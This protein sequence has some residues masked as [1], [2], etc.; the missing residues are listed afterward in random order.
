M[1]DKKLRENFITVIKSLLKEDDFLTKIARYSYNFYLNENYD[2]KKLSSLV[3]T[4]KSMT[5][6]D[7]FYLSRKDIL[8]LLQGV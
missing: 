5:A 4:L 6:S 1:T 3:D 7:D 2:N 8:H